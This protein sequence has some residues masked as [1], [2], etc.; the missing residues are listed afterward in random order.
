MHTT[1]MKH[2]KNRCSRPLQNYSAR[3]IMPPPFRTDQRGEVWLI[4]PHD[5]LHGEALIQHWFD[6]RATYTH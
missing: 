5:S 6:E 4:N 2:A 3:L 1:D